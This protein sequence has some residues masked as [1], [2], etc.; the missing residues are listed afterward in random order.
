MKVN[1]EIYAKGECS[2]QMG[3]AGNDVYG[4]PLYRVIPSPHYTE[5]ERVAFRIAEKKHC[6][7]RYEYKG[8]SLMQSYSIEYDAERFL[9]TMLFHVRKMEEEGVL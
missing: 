8:Y 2:V 7:R 9:D 5:R 3:R 4:N 6:Y 1:F